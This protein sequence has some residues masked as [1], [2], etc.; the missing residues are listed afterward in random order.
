MLLL[1]Q[2][3]SCGSNLK[4]SG[5]EHDKSPQNISAD[6]LDISYRVDRIKLVASRMFEQSSPYTGWTM[7]F[8]RNYAYTC[9]KQGYQTFLIAYRTAS[10]ITEARPLWVRMHGGGTGAFTRDS[11]GQSQYAPARFYPKAVI[12]ESASDLAE[13][14]NETG[15][16]TKIKAQ[17]DGFRFLV[18]SACDHDVFSG[19]GS[20]DPNNPFSPDENGDIRRA[21]G[22]PATLAALHFARTRLNTPHVFL[23]GTSAG[24]A[25]AFSMAYVLGQKGEKLSGAVLDSYVL[26]PYAKEINTCNGYGYPVDVLPLKIGPLSSE[27]HMPH[28]A[29]ARQQV[30]TPLHHVYSLGDMAH[31]GTNL[32]SIA[33][34]NGTFRSV[35]GHEAMHGMLS[36]AIEEKNP[37]GKPEKEPKSYNLPLC[38]EDSEKVGSCDLHS[39]TKYDARDTS[40]VGD[41]NA[42][43]TTWVREQLETGTHPFGVHAVGREGWPHVQALNASVRLQFQWDKYIKRGR[44]R[45]FKEMDLAMRVSRGM[46]GHLASLVSN[47][48]LQANRWTLPTDTTQMTITQ[49]LRIVGKIVERY[50]GDG[51]PEPAQDRFG[52]KLGL[53]LKGDCYEV[54]DGLFPDPETQAAIDENPIQD[55]QVEMEMWMLKPST[56]KMTCVAHFTGEAL[57]CP[58]DIRDHFN[59][60]RDRIKLKFANA[61]VIT[62]GFTGIELSAYLDGAK[63]ADKFVTP[64]AANDCKYVEIY[65]PGVPFLPKPYR[66]GLTPRQA[67][68][69]QQQTTARNKEL[70]RLL[71][72]EADAIDFHFYSNNPQSIPFLYRWLEKEMK[73]TARK[74]VWMVEAYAPMFPFALKGMDR[75]TDCSDETIAFRPPYFDPVLQADSLVKLHVL[76]FA[77]GIER[78]FYSHVTLSSSNWGPPYQRAT[79]IDV[80]DPAYGLTEGKKPAYFAYLQMRRQ[81]NAVAA[82]RVE[83]LDNESF[84]FDGVKPTYVLWSTKP[85]SSLEQMGLFQWLGQGKFQIEYLQVDPLAPRLERGVSAE[86]VLR[87]VEE[88]RPRVIFVSRDTFPGE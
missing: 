58:M 54:G 65:R 23:H 39:P 53:I 17:P 38:V 4:I 21:D 34:K 45:F 81:L 79:L 36:S 67:Q 88:E 43:I 56:S 49:W 50:D 77:G 69:A 47:W 26:N 85:K 14:L 11:T 64:A 44:E 20:P 87:A 27:A 25:G 74:P 2:L 28:N 71:L 10:A 22:L 24:S 86:R 5:N 7:E 37:G 30:K 68:L 83:R 51:S 70:L 29:V 66:I 40:G 6:T 41:Y 18:P 63:L 42:K 75:P 15:L 76:A 31:C 60:V 32:I 61:R 80:R 62:P 55:Y 59:R 3:I 13:H 72:P 82:L 1:L 48:D 16:V 19:I 35:P 8:Y 9:G 73:K 78:L 12:E 52:C 46:P 57:L 84:R 33:D